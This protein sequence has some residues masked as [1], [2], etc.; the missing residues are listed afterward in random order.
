MSLYH[1][2][3]PAAINQYRD[4][5]GRSA[6]LLNVNIIPARELCVDCNMRRTKATGKVTKRGFVCGMCRGRK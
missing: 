2:A 1:P 3:E 6:G 5:T 4:N